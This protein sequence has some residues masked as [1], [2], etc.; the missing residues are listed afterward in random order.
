MNR[1]PFDILKEILVYDR[2]FIIRKGEIFII[3]KIPKTDDRYRKLLSIK[4]KTEEES[5]HSWNY[6]V[7]LTISLK[8]SLYLYE[9][10]YHRE[11]ENGELKKY[12]SI[13]LQ[14]YQDGSLVN[15][16][17]KHIKMGSLVNTERVET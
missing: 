5:R 17:Y 4:I 15:T 13:V 10:N 12:F 3:N 1:L 6:G 2:R 9:D 14:T 11:E 7:T 8:K 16:E